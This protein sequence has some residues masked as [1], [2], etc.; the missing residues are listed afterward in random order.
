MALPHHD[1]TL[2]DEGGGAE[3][4]LVGTKQGGDY[5]ITARSHASVCL[6][7]DPP[8][9]PVGNQSLMGFRQTG[10]PVGACVHDRSQGTGAGPPIV[11][12]NQNMIGMRF[13]HTGRDGAYPYFGNQLDADSG[14]WVDVLQV[15]DELLEVLDRVDVMVRRRRD[16]SHA[17]CGEPDSSN[18]VVDLVP[19]QLAALTR[20]GSLCHLDLDIVGVDQIL[21]GDSESSGR[22][23]FHSRSRRVSVL[24][25]HIT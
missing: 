10:F 3:S 24:I 6:D 1:A 25:Y 18:P 5:D 20:L 21:G 23:L 14:P 13:G 2:R 15:V 11:A 8:P 19:G 17:R 22:H 9:Q 4:H 12:R 7:R 16:Q